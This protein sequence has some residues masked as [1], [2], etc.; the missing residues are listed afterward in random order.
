MTRIEVLGT[1][2]AKCEALYASAERAA[3]EKGIAFTIAK[4]V[5]PADIIRRGVLTTP[6]LAIDGEIRIAGRVPSSDAIK[7]M[8]P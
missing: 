6:A 1:G 2:C 5:D 4:V 7:A 8:L 3:R